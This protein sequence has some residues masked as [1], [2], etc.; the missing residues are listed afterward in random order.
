MEQFKVTQEFSS[1]GI[2]HTCHVIKICKLYANLY[3][4]QSARVWCCQVLNTKVYRINYQTVS[5][6]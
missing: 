1:R 6:A 4:F 5:C 3:T 2:P